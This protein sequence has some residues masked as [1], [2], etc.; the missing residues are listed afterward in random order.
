MED[1]KIGDN[2]QIIPVDKEGTIG[3]DKTSMN[4]Y[5]VDYN[6]EE[7][8]LFWH[9]SDLVLSELKPLD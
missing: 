5:W 6:D 8:G 4:N 9:E 7:G 2:V 1:F 3:G